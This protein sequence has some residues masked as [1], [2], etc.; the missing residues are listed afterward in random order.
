MAIYKKDYMP[1][2]KKNDLLGLNWYT[3]ASNTYKKGGTT[4]TGVAEMKKVI[5]EILENNKANILKENPNW[6]PIHTANGFHV[7]YDVFVGR[8]GTDGHN[9]RSAMEKMALDGLEHVGLIDNDKYVYTTSTNSY[10]DRDNPRI[11][12]TIS[13][14]DSYNYVVS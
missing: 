9:V 1:R 7:H 12:I 8:L 2:A 13:H 10:L 5:Y 11:D 4:T 3:N 6:N 14:K